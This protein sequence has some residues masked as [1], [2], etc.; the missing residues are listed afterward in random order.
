MCIYVYI[1][2]YISIHMCPDEVDVARAVHGHLDD[3]SCLFILSIYLRFLICLGLLF[4]FYLFYL[5]CFLFFR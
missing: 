1:Y 4:V 2:I 3:H 5:L